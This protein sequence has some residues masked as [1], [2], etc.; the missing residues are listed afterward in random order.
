MLPSIGCIL[1][2]NIILHDNV[3]VLLSVKESNIIFQKHLK[4]KCISPSMANKP[5]GTSLDS[6]KMNQMQPFATLVIFTTAP[7]L[8]MVC[9]YKYIYSFKYCT[10]ILTYNILSFLQTCNLL[11]H[12]Q[13][14]MDLVHQLFTHLFLWMKTLT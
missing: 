12:F 13:G 14:E 3:T 8:L 2:R 6:K 10:Y 1:E 11:D 4:L 9:F 7:T 5:H